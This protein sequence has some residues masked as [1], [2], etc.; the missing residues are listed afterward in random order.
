MASKCE[1]IRD[2]TAAIDCRLCGSAGAPPAGCPAGLT[3]ALCDIPAAAN[4]RMALF[5]SRYDPAALFERGAAAAVR[6]QI[7]RNYATAIAANETQLAAAYPGAPDL[8]IAWP[9]FE[10]CLRSPDG[11]P[12]G[13]FNNR[14]F[15]RDDC[16]ALGMQP[17]YPLG[18]AFA[19]GAIWK[20][21]KKPSPIPLAVD[22]IA[23]P[24]LATILVVLFIVLVLIALLWK[25]SRD[26]RRAPFLKAEAQYRA[27]LAR[28]QRVAAH[29]RPAPPPG[30]DPAEVCAAYV[31]AQEARGYDASQYREICGLGAKKIATDAMRG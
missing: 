20:A 26:V 7:E 1:I 25:A 15:G 6:A 14:Y 30:R 18:K 16:A 3:P 17:V 21:G 5:A 8:R 22:Y 2:M 12:S 23:N 13:A 24:D 4:D 11:S 10:R 19:Q 9:D 31:A 29:G 28:A 27:R